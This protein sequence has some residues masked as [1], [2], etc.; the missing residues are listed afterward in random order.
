MVDVGTGGHTV[1]RE[2]HCSAL[3]KMLKKGVTDVLASQ[4][5]NAH[6]QK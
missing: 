6:C 4:K 3:L 5:A 1:L 2:E